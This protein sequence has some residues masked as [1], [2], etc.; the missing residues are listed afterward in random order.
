[1]S[2]LAIEKK[3]LRQPKTPQLG[4]GHIFVNPLYYIVSCI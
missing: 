2:F 4:S 1:M 3:Y